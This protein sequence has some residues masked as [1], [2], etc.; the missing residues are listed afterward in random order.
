VTLTNVGT[1]SLTYHQHRRH[2]GRRRDFGE[3]TTLELAG[4]GE[5]LHGQA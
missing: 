5:E 3:T 1:T 2:W 4:R